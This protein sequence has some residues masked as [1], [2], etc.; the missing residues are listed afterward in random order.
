MS[1]RRPLVPVF[2]LPGRP[3]YIIL[4]N[5]C[6]LLIDKEQALKR[7]AVDM[8][9]TFT[10]LVYIDD[11]TEQIINGKVR[12]TPQDIGQAVMNVVKKMRL[13]L[14]DIAIF[15]NGTTAGLNAIAQRKGSKVGLITTEG[16]RDV[17]EMA[18]GSM[19]NPYDPM[20]KKPQPLVPRYL[21]I[22]VRERMDYAGKEVEPL[23]VAD[24]QEAVRKFR[25]NGVEAI[26]VCFLHSHVNP[27]HERM[28]G[29]I[30][31]ELWP[32]VT[33][34]LSHRVA[35]Q[36]REYERMSS[37][38]ISAYMAKAI[39]GYLGRMDKNLKEEQ[40]KGQLLILGPGGVMGVE[41]VKENLLYT[42]ASG[43]AGGAAGA[44][45][46]AGLCGIKN[47]ITMDVGGTS[48]DVSLIKDGVNIEKHQSEVMGF[49]LLMSG[50]EVESIGAGGGSIARVDSAGLLTVGPESAGAVPGP[51][52]YGQGG[53]EPTV[54]DAALVNGI[55]D[56]DYF[57]GG[58][59]RLDV[60][61]AVRGIREIA[62]KLDIDLNKA[63]DGIL[64]V[65][66]N[67]MTAATTEKLI[68]RGY[69]PREFSIM[70]FGGGG[71]LFAGHIARDMSIRKVV[72]PPGPGVFC[73]WGIL[74]MNIVHSYTRSYAR[75]LDTLDVQE[76]AAIYLEME[77]EAQETLQLEGMSEDDIEFVRSMDMGYEY[78]RHYIETP[79]PGGAFSVNSKDI[80]R[81]SFES[82]HENRYGHRIKAPLITV[83]IR[84]KAIG[85]IKDVSI[86]EIEKDSEIPLEAIKPARK[87]YLEGN[88]VE[89]PIFER[90]RLL[91]GNMIPGPAIIEEPYHTT[92]VMPGQT[93]EVDK[94]GNLVITVGGK[95]NA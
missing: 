95:T 17:L 51:M 22:G 13:D 71:G 38:V 7:I 78:Q 12:S 25:E 72:V 47:F 57:L 30:L 9:G 74:T 62:D 69:D 53:K 35:R 89:T 31:K 26:A 18:R 42:L 37:T 6:H 94:Y 52:A 77:K 79:V 87:V 90:G 36:I 1:N 82:I 85:K 48:F 88:F 73:A 70:A 84:L 34:S 45:Y 10:D 91:C 29:E 55:I 4:N 41:A 44:A 61:L 33:V 11:E 65:A 63:A 64:A 76:L 16:F 2:H 80:I 21:C 58:E 56:P 8:G 93:L 15:I 43:T 92:L 83:N 68:G 39:M 50:I 28:A 81:E 14:S 5:N 66:R 32:E 86:K 46:A 27:E 23:C 49:P 3:G 67:N 59:V 54:T 75:T 19:K 60:E 24:L 20:S 40:F